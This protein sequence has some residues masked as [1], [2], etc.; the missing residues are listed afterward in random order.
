M[1]GCRHQV[2]LDAF[3]VHQGKVQKAGAQWTALFDPNAT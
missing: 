1:A 3:Q 2:H